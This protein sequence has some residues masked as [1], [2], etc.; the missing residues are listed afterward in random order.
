MAKPMTRRERLM[1]SVRG[2]PVDRPPVCFYELNG[3]DEDPENDDPFNIYSH[4][5]WRPLLELTREKTDRIVMRGV[6]LKDAPPNP[7]AELTSVET[8]DDNG[9]RF[10]RQTIRAGKRVLTSLSRRDPGINTVWT[11]EHLLKDT[12]DL[13]A[14]LELPA[15][16]FG[17]EPEVAGVLETEAKLGDT[18]IVMLETGDPLCAVAPLFEFGEFT[19]VAM[20]EPKLFHRAL[21][22]WARFFYER[23]AAVAQALPGHLWRICGSEYA[24]P[25]Y[26]P[27]ALFR[28]YVLQYD[29][30][31]VEAIQAHGGYA[32]VHSHGRLKDVLDHI[33]ATGCLGLDPIEPP[34]QGDVELSYVRERYGRQLTLF[35]NLETSDIGALPTE[36][37]A[38][39]VARALKE[40]TAGEGRGFVLM[41]ASCPHGREL[42][43]LTLRNYEKIIEMIEQF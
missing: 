17:G 25:P 11:L 10:T 29:K 21:D 22:K 23:T 38:E 18:G 27:P 5:S 34:P 14:W 6:P 37:F 4:P 16:E 3:L 28:E 12:D 31:I 19:I 2:E 15:P 39:K 8:Y 30:P 24:S 36:Q 13:R 32:R 33:V 9:R 41:P 7:L 20:T 43:P 1:A 35:G 42:A 26:L 40:G